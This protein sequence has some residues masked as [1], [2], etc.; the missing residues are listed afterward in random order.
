MGER[1]YGWVASMVGSYASVTSAFLSVAASIIASQ[2]VYLSGL[3]VWYLVLGKQKWWSV[4]QLDTVCATGLLVV[5]DVAWFA[6]AISDS[7]TGNV[8]SIRLEWLIVMIDL[9]LCLVAALNVVVAIYCASKLKRRG[10]LAVGNLSWLF[11]AASFLWLLRCAFVLAV[12][13]KSVVRDWTAAELTLQRILNPILDFWVSATVLGL[14]TF[15]LRNPVWSDPSVF[16][17]RPHW[18]Q[19]QAYGQYEGHYP[20]PQYG[21][22][23]QQQQQ[24]HVYE[25][26]SPHQYYQQQPTTYQSYR[27][28]QDNRM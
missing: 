11:L 10:D 2:A 18:Q 8:D 27:Q 14:V 19:Q 12:D 6:K 24:P 21:Q 26:S 3:C 25:H 23:Q 22:Q 5:L 4:V 15:M 16:S 7:V 17:D 9:T 1:R 28:P 13:L 20:Q